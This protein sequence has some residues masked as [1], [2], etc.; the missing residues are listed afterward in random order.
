MGNEK[1]DFDENKNENENKIENRKD[2]ATYLR[3]LGLMRQSKWNG[4]CD[5]GSPMLSAVVVC[6]V[7][8]KDNAQWFLYNV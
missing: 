8:V 2:S 4:R 5:G 7:L 6:A 1:K 3:T